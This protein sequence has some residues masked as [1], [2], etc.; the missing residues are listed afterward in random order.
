MKFQRWLESG[1]T[2]NSRAFAMFVVVLILV[3]GSKV[4]A[5]D[6]WIEAAPFRANPGDD[7]LLILRIGEH[8][9]GDALINVPELYARFM[10][11][12]AKGS[13]PVAGEPGDDPA[14][15]LSNIPPGLSVVIYESKA[16][17]VEIPP[18][19]FGNYLRTEG[20]DQAAA[21]RERRKE[22]GK[23]AR[24]RYFRYAKSLV[25][26]GHGGKGF[27]H[28]FGM[29]LELIPER[30]P[31]LVGT[32]SLPVKLKLNKK[33]AAG[34]LVHAFR[35]EAPDKKLAMRTDAAGRAVLAL[36]QPGTWLVKA[37]SMRRLPDGEDEEW[38]S[39]WASLTFERPAR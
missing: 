19:K 30:D 14:G 3:A 25:R 24:E 9:S 31:T 37:V 16:Y 13:R 35:R 11:L 36:D 2:G 29:W 38:E 17:K 28:D 23:P 15:R 6:F 27:D 39:Y 8:F 20:L 33:P 7:S 34:V 26:A 5:H 22:T 21:E 1:R 12:D 32:V 10:V 4:H 18:E